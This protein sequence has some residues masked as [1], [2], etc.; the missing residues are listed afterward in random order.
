MEKTKKTISKLYVLNLL[1]Q[2][3]KSIYKINEKEGKFDIA[4]FTFIKFQ[5]KSIP[6]LIANNYIIEGEPYNIINI[7]K[8]NFSRK[9]ELG[10]CRYK[11]KVNNISVIE[12]KG[13]KINDLDFFEIDDNL[14]DENYEKYFSN[15]DIFILNYENHDKISLSFGTIKTLSSSDIVYSFNENSNN[16]FPIFN[17]SNNKLIGIT[18]NSLN[19]FNKGLCFKFIINK[20]INEY[21]HIPNLKNE[22][23]ISIKVEKE[24]I[25]KSVYFLDNPHKA[26]IITTFDL[27]F[28]V[29]FLSNQPSKIFVYSVERVVLI[30][31]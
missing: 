19:Y 7:S 25:N 14:F 30:R 12:I 1:D 29:D 10:N 15:E 23:I 28:L 31:F 16:G 9:I 5:N 4:F 2:L 18:N 6:V 24:N 8:N 27:Y 3:N 17:S 22:I 13:D 11:N 20:F 26:R 21:K